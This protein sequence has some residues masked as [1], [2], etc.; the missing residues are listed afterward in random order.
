MIAWLALRLTH[1][2]APIAVLA[3][4]GALSLSIG[5]AL[6]QQIRIERRNT[7][8]SAQ[9]GSIQRLQ[10]AAQLAEATSAERGAQ[11]GQE[12]VQSYV[13][14]NE[15]EAPLMER[16]VDRV[17]V[18]CMRDPASAPNDRLSVPEGSPDPDGR[19]QAPRNNG[20]REFAAAIGRDLQACRTEM[21]K[22]S[23]LQTWLRANGG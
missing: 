14:R 10:A 18:V 22:L 6:A 13:Q 3:L 11:T 7:I 20:D 21:T 5:I 12:A 8:I 15:Q 2:L 4:I 23:E 19:A 16:V 17:R 9:A 1:R